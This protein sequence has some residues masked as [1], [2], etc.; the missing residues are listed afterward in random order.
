ML[1][2][3]KQI[4]ADNLRLTQAYC[5]LQ[6]KND[7]NDNAKVFRSYNPAYGDKNL[8]SF[9]TE[10]FDFEIEPNLRHCTLTKWI[11]DPTGRENIVDNLFV[12]QINHKKQFIS[13]IEMDKIC[14]GRILVSQIDCTVIDGASEVQSLG[15]VD[16]YDIPPID[17]W[18]FITR[19][20]ESRLLFAWIPNEFVHYA[21]EA[22][23]VNC[24]DCINW[25]DI[26]Y[27]RELEM[28]Y[29][30]GDKSLTTRRT[31]NISIANSGAD[32]KSMNFWSRV[33]QLFGA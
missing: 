10:R 23:E 19:T 16:I 7:I 9:E 27:P 12:E 25:A 17:T 11:V 18:F 32:K 22:V 13:S 28:Y 5:D 31:P 24:V 14:P 30:N 2:I 1:N 6:L 4:F 15:L 20:K 29:S 21:N 8:F 33:K 3:D 26:W